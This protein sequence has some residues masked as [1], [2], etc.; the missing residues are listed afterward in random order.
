MNYDPSSPENNEATAKKAL[1]LAPIPLD[2][3]LRAGSLPGKSLQVALIIRHLT[4]I[5]RSTWVHLK[6]KYLRQM[7][8]S[9]DAKRR[10][11][12]CLEGAGLIAVSARV[13]GNP[14]VRIINQ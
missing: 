8:I 3:I 11:L 1:F 12:Q 13:G 14:S 10:A 4:T 5:E 9:R 6:N 7:S 2:W